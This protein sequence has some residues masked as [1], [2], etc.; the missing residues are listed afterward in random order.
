MITMI[1]QKKS[2]FNSSD[3]FITTKNNK[4]AFLWRNISFSF[5]LLKDYAQVQ[6]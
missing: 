4:K 1:R 5:N 3:G 6:N 2:I